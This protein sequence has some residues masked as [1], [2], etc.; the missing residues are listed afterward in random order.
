MAGN[1]PRTLRVL[2]TLS[3]VAP[4]D[5]TILIDGESGTGKDLVARL[6]HQTSKRASGPWVT[7]NC[8]AIPQSL[9][10][11]ELFGALKGAYT[12]IDKDKSGLIEK[13]DGGTLFLDEIGELPMEAQ[14]K[15]LRVLQS[16]RIRA[17][18]SNEDKAVNVRVIA[19]TNRD[20][21]EE[22]NAGRFRLDLFYRI[23]VVHVELIPLR[24]R[25]MEFP[26]LVE[27]ILD[28]LRNKGINVPELRTSAV[29]VLVQHSWPGNI[30]EL[31]NVIERAVL[32][33]GGEAIDGEAIREQIVNSPQPMV[34][35]KMA[36]SPGIDGYPVTMSLTEVTD[37]HIQKVLDHHGGNKTRAARD[38]GVN[39]KT[40]YNRTVAR[41]KENGTEAE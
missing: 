40:I 35:N 2:R 7:L 10:E 23:H 37:A 19:A 30:R 16:G 31:E 34:E 38:L 20:L 8:G 14:V 17:V 13:A 12:G 18:G 28:N 32:L 33:S 4:T 25:E 5:S 11:S 22:V 1:D 3:A 29:E 6:V 21:R 27:S 39:V 36:I 41:A 9:V 15:L 24:D 26:H